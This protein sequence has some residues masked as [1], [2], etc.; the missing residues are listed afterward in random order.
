MV[1]GAITTQ[2]GVMHLQVLGFD[3]S[4]RELKLEVLNWQGTN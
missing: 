2:R 4:H 1:D 3:H